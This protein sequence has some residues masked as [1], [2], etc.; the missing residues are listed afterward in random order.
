MPPTGAN[1]GPRERVS[2]ER[3][4]AGGATVIEITDRAPFAAVMEPVYARYAADPRLA[5]LVRQI[6]TTQ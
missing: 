4:I 5:E 6:R 1:Y 2:R 3:V